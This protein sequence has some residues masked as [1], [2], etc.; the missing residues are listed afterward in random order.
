MLVTQDRSYDRLAVNAGWLLR[1]R[2]VAVMGQLITIGVAGV[3][4]AVRLPLLPLF[5]IIGFTT[6]TNVAF[7]VWLRRH[8][9]CHSTPAELL[10]DQRVLAVLMTLDLLALTALLYFSGGVTNPFV[11]FY[12]LNVALAAVVL[13]VGWAWLMA[14]L[15]GACFLGLFLVGEPLPEF[16][17]PLVIPLG[18]FVTLTHQ[19][20]GFLVS[21]VACG[22]VAVYF[23]TRVTRELRQREDDLRVAEHLQARSERL[24]ALAT[25]AA[26]AAHELAS[27]LSTIAVIAKDLSRQLEQA[28]LP[29][30]VLE[31]VRLIR[32]ELDHCRRILNEMRSAAGGA[33]GEEMQAVSVSRL[34]EEAL[35]GLRYPSQVQLSLPPEIATRSLQIPLVATSQ[36]IRGV[37]RNAFD[38]SPADAQVVLRVEEERAGIALKVI[39]KGLGMPPE[40]LARIG[41]PFFTTKEPGQ[42][43]GLGLFLAK[44]VLNRLGGELQLKSAAGEGTTATIYLPWSASAGS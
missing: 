10:R 16:T 32:S 18:R 26:G 4:L 25:L 15:A 42:G 38:A 37:I 13:P 28:E 43:M 8:I 12:L 36:A 3:A 35:T 31:D 14:A 40:V 41:E 39:D 44:N 6:A 24:E 19:Q 9:G 2:W 27:P 30:A 1:L 20:L 5:A 11:L 7:A 21:M 22:G 23:I 29:E 33:A 34:L 17:Q